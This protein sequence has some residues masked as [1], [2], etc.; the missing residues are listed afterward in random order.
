MAPRPG[1]RGELEALYARWEPSVVLF[2]SQHFAGPDLEDLV[3]VGRLGAWRALNT[4]WHGANASTV[5]LNGARWAV[6]D[7][8]R[9]PNWSLQIGGAGRGARVQVQK[10]HPVILEGALLGHEGETVDL[11][12]H[13]ALLGPDFVPE[14]LETRECQARVVA[15]FA[16]ALPHEAEILRRYYWDGEAQEAIGRAMGLSQ[17]RVHQV[18]TQALRRCR[19]AWG[20]RPTSDER[21]QARRAAAAA[22]GPRGPCPQGHAMVGENAM[23]EGEGRW[24]CRECRRERQRAAARERRKET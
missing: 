8:R 19:E 13:E 1:S 10:D 14:L 17:S 6:L 4:D 5:C 24:R 16:L 2:I 7:Y 22:R 15:A 12:E 21:H 9:G 11:E 20:E 18:R 3:Q 23:L